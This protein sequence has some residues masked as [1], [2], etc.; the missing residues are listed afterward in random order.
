M[1]AQVAAADA[2]AAID[3]FYAQLE[4]CTVKPETEGG[5]FIQVQKL[6]FWMRARSA[7]CG[8]VNTHRLLKAVYGTG[9]RP[10]ESTC[11]QICKAGRDCC[12]LIF[13]I[14]LEIGL[15]KWIHRV[16]ESVYDKDLPANLARSTFLAFKTR[17]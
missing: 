16:Q 12:I 1:N 7:D 15:G 13:S 5:E 9:I 4:A 3:D 11:T 10:I 8:F 17:H 6:C 2:R 14:L